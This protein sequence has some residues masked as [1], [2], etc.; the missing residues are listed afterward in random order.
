MTNHSIPIVLGPLPLRYCDVPPAQ[1]S[2]PTLTL[3][4]QVNA[5]N[6]SAPDGNA[7]V[8][9]LPLPRRLSRQSQSNSHR[10]TVGSV[11]SM[12]YKSLMSGLSIADETGEERYRS[13]PLPM[14]PAPGPNDP[15]PLPPLPTMSMPPSG[16]TASLVR[17]PPNGSRT[18]TPLQSPHPDQTPTSFLQSY[19]QGNG[20]SEPTSPTT[21][22]PQYGQLSGNA[23]TSMTSDTS[24]P[25]AYAQTRRQNSV[26]STGAGDYGQPRTPISPTYNDSM[27]VGG[28]TSDED[29]GYF[30]SSAARKSFDREKVSEKGLFRLRK[31][32]S[33]KLTR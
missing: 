2:A 4:K 1:H 23:A 8:A 7:S 11:Q 3:V 14:A 28:A 17:Q 6:E 32:S 19:P 22:T 18:V 16:S 5:S 13:R 10:T 24:S 25:G 20:L 21:L 26:S 15:A 9:D 31:N 33:V 12:E 30:K 29:A 27:N